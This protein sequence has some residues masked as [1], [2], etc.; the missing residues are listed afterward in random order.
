MDGFAGLRL[1]AFR[2]RSELRWHQFVRSCHFIYPDEAAVKGSR[3][4][5][6]ALLV[7]IFSTVLL[8]FFHVLFF[9]SCIFLFWH[10]QALCNRCRFGRR[11][12]DYPYAAK[13]CA[14]IWP[15]PPLIT[16]IKSHT[17]CTDF[18]FAKCK[19]CLIKC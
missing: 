19:K 18:R 2:D 1:L 11:G 3:N 12:V 10:Y 17:C 7:K 4:I 6:T 13:H 8:F 16:L 14:C 9:L 15:I 5:F